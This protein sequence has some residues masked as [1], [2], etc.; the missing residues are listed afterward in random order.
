MW[1]V[2]LKRFRLNLREGWF[3]GAW[4]VGGVM[5]VVAVWVSWIDYGERVR[6]FDAGRLGHQLA[7]ERAQVYHLLEL[8]IERRPA[9]LSL[10]SRGVGEQLGSSAA[11]R[12]RYGEV[13]FARRDRAAVEDARR[14]NVDLSWVL[15]LVVGFTCVFSGHAVINGERE[16]GTLKQQLA[17]GLPRSWLLSG[18][19]L[20]GVLAFAAPCG[21]LFL[22]FSAFASVAGLDLDASGWLRVGLFFALVALY[23][24]FWL[25]LSLALS[26][27]CRHTETSLILGIL[28]WALSASLYPQIAGWAAARMAPSVPAYA[29]AAPPGGA[30]VEGREAIMLQRNVRSAE[31]RIHQRFSWLLPV[32]AFRSA[33]QSLAGTSAADHERF[34]DSVDAAEREFE[35]WQSEKLKKHPVRAVRVVHGVPLDI[36]GLPEP[37]HE[38]ASL[39]QALRQASL[40]AGALLFGTVALLLAAGA[41]VERLDVR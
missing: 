37:V 34:L 1:T 26:A 38:P 8:G 40:P 29:D 21:L 18:E 39:S 33:G 13:R 19:F 11:I 4:A 15:A 14:L 17:R 31:S 6:L 24:G 25:A 27:F 20:G 9:P 30:E 32:T 7:A 35:A 41:G 28:A 3:L 22:G 16:A 12:G 10:L 2:A 5:A 23:G 36:S